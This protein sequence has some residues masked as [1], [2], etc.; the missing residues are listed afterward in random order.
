MW[1]AE[2]VSHK[3]HMHSRRKPK[4]SLAFTA[5]SGEKHVSTF[6]DSTLVNNDTTTTS[7]C[8]KTFIPMPFS[9]KYSSPQSHMVH[10][11]E[12]SRNG[13]DRLFANSVVDNSSRLIGQFFHDAVEGNTTL[14]L[15]GSCHSWFGFTLL[16]DW[17]SNWFS[18]GLVWFYDTQLKTA[19]FV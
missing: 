7:F 2:Q 8:S 6:P 12:T 14:S 17:L 18:I 3:A 19:L 11:S 10:N 15:I 4:Q 13:G 5:R 16:C 1:L 9:S